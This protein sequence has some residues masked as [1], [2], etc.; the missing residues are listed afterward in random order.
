MESDIILGQS[1]LRRKAAAALPSLYMDHPSGEFCLIKTFLTSLGWLVPKPTKP[2]SPS[3]DERYYYSYYWKHC[4]KEAAHTHTPTPTHI[5]TGRHQTD[6][7]AEWEMEWKYH[8]ELHG[9]IW[10]P[11]SNQTNQLAVLHDSN[12][13]CPGFYLCTGWMGTYKATTDTHT[14]TSHT[15]FFGRQ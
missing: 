9:Y 3:P 5:L 1:Q 10:D 6:H 8:T 12:R 4:R 13:Y 2:T 11:N 14:H 7:K 15:I